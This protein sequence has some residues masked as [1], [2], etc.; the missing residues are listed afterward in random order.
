MATFCEMFCS[1]CSHCHVNELSQNPNAWDVLFLHSW[2]LYFRD[3]SF[4][5]EREWKK[6]NP[7][8]WSFLNS[9]FMVFSF[10]DAAAQFPSYV[11]S[12]YLE[13]E[14]T[15]EIKPLGC[16]YFNGFCIKDTVSVQIAD[17]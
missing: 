8:S 4:S 9:N 12:L 15:D 1:Q 10:L 17:S 2:H 13:Q 14:W 3:K 7:V 6:F 11:R 5:K 16:L